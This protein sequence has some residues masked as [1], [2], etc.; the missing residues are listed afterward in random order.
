M[1]ANVIIARILSP[2]DFGRL[3]IILFFML[4]AN[5]LL[6]GGLS[7]ALLRKRD[8]REVDYSTIFLFNLGISLSCFLV[9]V[10]SSNYIAT[11]YN[12]TLLRY[13]LIV[14]SS[15]L[16]VNAFQ[17]AP[18]TKM[19]AEMRYKARSAYLLISVLISSIV[20]VL[21]AYGGFGIWSLVTSQVLRA[22]IF[23]GLLIQFER[24]SF[25]LS[26]SPVVFKEFFSFGVNTSVSSLLTVMFD[27]IY[28]LVLG[29]Y[30]SLNQAGC[31]FQAKKLQEVP[32]GVLT[33]LTQGVIYTTLAKFQDDK[34]LF[35]RAYTKMFNFFVALL[36]FI[37]LMFFIYS[38]LI[39]SLLLG[40]KW[41]AAGYFLK[42]LSLSS[43]FYI[44]ESF[45]RM[46][47]KIFNETKKLLKLEILKKSI[48]FSTIVIGIWLRNVEV[49]L[50]GFLV[51]SLLGY[52]MNYII[53]RKILSIKSLQEIS[54][55]LY[56]IGIIF[57]IIILVGLAQDFFH[58]E[59]I[60]SLLY[61]P[62]ILGVYYL[63]LRS[64]GI[65]LFKYRNLL[66]F[67]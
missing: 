50:Y 59:P 34:L 57:L 63:F 11:F 16:I 49:L 7:G 3:G 19:M 2:E 44:Q 37:T 38:E 27:N 40:E 13:P 43:F 67:K 54:V 24:F 36:G 15:I 21:L 28:Q 32:G 48:Q 25:K 33:M 22:L 46:I 17:I 9:I 23:T 8:I 66:N 1:I 52:I 62:W 14:T 42:I 10:L 61:S 26:F 47:F 29:K 58:L 20:G 51:V 56:V 31:F 30:F 41:I 55:V 65:D 12:D 39:I 35:Y 64:V 60:T 5:I 53:S 18:N 45:N 4:I 6:E